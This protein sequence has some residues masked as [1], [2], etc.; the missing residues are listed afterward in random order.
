VSGT[1]ANIV[2]HLCLHL[3]P[4]CREPFHQQIGVYGIRQITL[5]ILTSFLVFSCIFCSMPVD[6]WCSFSNCDGGD[7]DRAVDM[8]VK[9]IMMVV[10]VTG[11]NSRFCRK[12]RFSATLST[13]NPTF[14]GLGSNPGP[15]GEKPVPDLWHIPTN[16]G[17][18]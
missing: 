15:R 9:A 7:I 18:N 6:I 8:T 2:Y 12:T 5:N 10:T 14:T 16:S 3:F 4:I 13:I 1:F 17:N 11:D